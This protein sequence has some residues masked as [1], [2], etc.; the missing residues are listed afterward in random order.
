MVSGIIGKY[1]DQNGSNHALGLQK[2]PFFLRVGVLG[3]A[4]T[5]SK[6]LEHTIIKYRAKCDKLL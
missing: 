5:S 4:H 1:L 2:S 6:P 3:R